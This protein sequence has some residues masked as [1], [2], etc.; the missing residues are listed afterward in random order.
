MV[1]SALLCCLQARGDGWLQTAPR[2]ELD[3]HGRRRRRLPLVFD[4]TK[5]DRIARKLLD[6]T[7]ITELGWR[8][9]PVGPG[10]GL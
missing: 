4:A 2:D 9:R 3:L 10:A 6:S 1:D 8:Y 7:R 5:P